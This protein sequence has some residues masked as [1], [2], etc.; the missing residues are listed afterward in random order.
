LCLVV[1]PLLY[2]FFFQAEDGIRDR[3]VTGVQTCAL[4]ISCSASPSVKASKVVV[5]APSTE[6][7]MATHAKSARP[8]RTAWKASEGEL[9]GNCCTSLTAPAFSK[10]TS[11][12]SVKV[13]ARP[14]KATVEGMPA[15]LNHYR[16][17]VW[18]L[19]LA[20]RNCPVIYRR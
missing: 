11:A 5:T 8:S 10:Y 13:P 9:T 6:F 2:F 14:N 15:N 17:C 4:P 3:N 20:F 1:D 16:G 18:I 19:A 12:A 7:S